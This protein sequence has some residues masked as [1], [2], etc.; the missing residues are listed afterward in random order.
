MRTYRLT[1][2]FEVSL[3]AGELDET[4]VRGLQR[5][6]RTYDDGRAPFAVELIAEGVRRAIP[7]DVCVNTTTMR[8][9]AVERGAPR[10]ACHACGAFDYDGGSTCDECGETAIEAF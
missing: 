8:A 10:G 5:H 7:G 2:S 3:M 4:A 6:L 1:L 9:S